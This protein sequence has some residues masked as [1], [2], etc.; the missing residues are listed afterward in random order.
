MET[1][2]NQVTTKAKDAVNANAI[3]KTIL[4]LSQQCPY[5]VGSRD[6]CKLIELFVPNILKQEEAR[7]AFLAKESSESL[8]I[9]KSVDFVERTLAASRDINPYSALAWLLRFAAG[10]V[11]QDLDFVQS[12]SESIVAHFSALLIFVPH[13]KPSKSMRKMAN[14]VAEVLIWSRSDT[15]MTNP[16]FV[17]PHFEILNSWLPVTR[18][19]SSV[20]SCPC[21]VLFE[22]SVFS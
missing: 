16:D 6:V 8:K 10:L 3:S 18:M 4:V 15:A 11:D 7:S 1:L 21:K 2:F 19:R 14:A 5:V 9:A 20:L 22:N 17:Q 13:K 12:C